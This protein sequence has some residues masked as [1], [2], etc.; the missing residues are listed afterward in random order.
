MEKLS[1]AIVALS[2]KEAFECLEGGATSE[3]VASAEKVL[4]IL[5]PDEYTWFLRTYG[6][7]V[8]FGHAILGLSPNDTDY[9]TLYF[10]GK[11]RNAKLPRG[12]TPI[13]T[14]GN[15]VMKYGGGGYY[16][17]FSK[18]TKFE[19]NVKLFTDDMGGRESEHWD[20]FREFVE[21]FCRF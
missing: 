3:Q 4:G 17:L 7:V 11:M 13:P 10:T 9:D 1:N 12:F 16:F 6:Y 2:K 20:T 15:I 5:F 8:W 18:G 19:G 14:E 21:Y